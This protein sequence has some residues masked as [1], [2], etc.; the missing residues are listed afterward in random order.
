MTTT[1]LNRCSSAESSLDTY[2]MRHTSTHPECF[3][4][5]EALRKATWTQRMHVTD[6]NDLLTSVVCDHYK[7]LGA[8]LHRNQTKAEAMS[9]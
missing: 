2:G 6:T 5:T 1:N 3:S 7:S 9:M 4:H 8:L